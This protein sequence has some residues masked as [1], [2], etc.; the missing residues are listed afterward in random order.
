ML[1]QFELRVAVVKEFETVAGAPSRSHG[2]ML[3][4]TRRTVRHLCCCSAARAEGETDTGKNSPFT[5]Q[6]IDAE[7]LPVCSEQ[8]TALLTSGGHLCSTPELD[9]RGTAR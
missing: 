1:W 2:E 3:E 5:N 9:S 7:F 6:Q 8:Q 4:E